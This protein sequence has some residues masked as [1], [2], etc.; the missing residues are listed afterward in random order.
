[1]S[2]E[3]KFRRYKAFHTFR[4]ALLFMITRGSE[5]GGDQE[6]SSFTNRYDPSANTPPYSPFLLPSTQ[7][8]PANHTSSSPRRPASPKKPASTKPATPKK[9]ASAIQNLSLN[10]SPTQSG[11]SRLSDL[12]DYQ[13]IRSIS[14]D[15]LETLKS[16]V[17]PTIHCTVDM[18]DL[19]DRY[20]VAMGYNQDAVTKIEHAFIDANGRSG[21]FVNDLCL[22]GMTR[23]EAEFLWSI[24]R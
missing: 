21:K 15:V 13:H 16:P 1:M 11:A 2:R 9:P 3:E 8:L 7:S 19:V 20:I 22:D 23:V 5:K 6:P 14:G 17:F 4:G 18:G 24:S 12:F 10:S